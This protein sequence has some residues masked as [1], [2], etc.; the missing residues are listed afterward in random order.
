MRRGASPQKL[1]FTA[2]TLYIPVGYSPRRLNSV[3]YAR[4]RAA[5][6][7]GRG[8]LTAF[9]I[10]AGERIYAFP[11]SRL[12]T[13]GV[14]RLLSL[15][16]SNIEK[17][18]DG[19]ARWADIE[20]LQVRAEAI[21][22][23]PA[24]ATRAIAALVSAAFA[25]QYIWPRIDHEPADGFAALD[26][27]GNAYALVVAGEWWRLVTVN[28]LHGS[29]QHFFNN[30]VFLLIFG[31]LLE[32][33][34][35]PVFLLNV[36]LATG[37]VAGAASAFLSTHLGPYLYAVGLSGALFGV[38][39]ALAALQVRRWREIPAGFRLSRRSWVV[40]LGLNLIV[41]L[42]TAQVDSAAHGGGL[43]AGFV[44]GWTMTLGRRDDLPVTLASLGQ[45]GVASR[46]A[47]A[48][49]AIVWL[50][51]I[52]EQAVHAA[53]P[54]ERLQD[55]V[56]LV[57][58]Q[59]V[60]PRANAL[61]LN[62]LAYSIAM[63]PDAMPDQLRDARRLAAIAL[64]QV[65]SS[66]YLVRYRTAVGDTLA[67]L[68]DR[69][70]ETDRALRLEATLLPR[71]YPLVAE[72]LARMLEKRVAQWGPVVIGGAVAAPTLRLDAGTLHF[73]AVQP[74]PKGGY[75]IALL[76]RNG[77][78]E[79]MIN[80]YIPP[81]F[82]GEQLLPLPVRYGPPAPEPPDALWLDGG[83]RIDVAWFDSG[84]CGCQWPSMAPEWHALRHG[85]AALP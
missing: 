11:L 26:L 13:D 35:G 25:L 80:M 12:G 71:A 79:G 56:I 59:L 73:V 5:N 66:K 75:V 30:L 47:L 2:D 16:R 34:A 70:G 53:S 6:L 61:V 45:P 84:G 17:L 51:G 77:G 8:W 50:G 72:H 67:V 81:G 43:C 27:G 39:G 57:R 40:L 33:I 28:L 46:I 58:D 42:S 24:W 29:P 74:V 69:L 41:A 82:S 22:G 55:R 37:I 18:P 15:L 31:T 60:Q 48:G 14:A 32:R 76:R 54:S 83:S 44:L 38:V 68:D 7:A 21:R 63:R 1:R 65:S 85:G 3:P 36:V 23:R 49:L 19:A 4:I 10:D 52:A 78:V 9:A 20:A 62:S 64:A